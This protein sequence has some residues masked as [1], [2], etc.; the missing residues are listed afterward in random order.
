MSSELAKIDQALDE[1]RAAYAAAAGNASVQAEVKSRF[2]KVFQQRDRYLIA[3]L[4]RRAAV[5]NALTSQLEEAVMLI[6]THIANFPIGGLLSVLKDLGGGTAEGQHSGAGQPVGSA[7]NGQA[8]S[9]AGSQ[10]GAGGN[11]GTGAPSVS[12]GSTGGLISVSVSPT[13]FDALCRVAQSEVGGF[14]KYGNSELKGGLAAVVDTIINRV[15][16]KQYPNS[17]QGVVDQP[18]QFSAI[19]ST[20]SWTG[21]P[22]ANATVTEIVAEHLKYRVNGGACTVKGATHFLNP[23][24]SSST[25]LAQW[26][27]HVKEN[28]V[29]V[30]GNDAE[31]FV[32]YHGFAPGTPRTRDYLLSYEGSSSGFTAAGASIGQAQAVGSLAEKIATICNEELAYFGDGSK[33][34]GD[35]PQYL[36]VGEYW[37]S[38]GLPYDGRTQIVN[39]ATGKSHN[40]PWSS[41]F[42]SHVLKKAGAGDGFKY[43]QAHCHYVQDF[44]NGRPNGVYEAMHPDHYAPKIGDILH[45]GRGDAKQHDYNAA[46]GDYLGDSFYSSH[47]DIVVDVDLASGKITTVGG[48]V[49]NSVKTKTINIGTDG[50]L[51]PRRENGSD[52]PWIAVLKLVK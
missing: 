11:S 12:A 30:W 16:H 46:R 7:S 20:G 27:N 1:L 34:E 49:S 21:L 48:N 39:H 13:D 15:A 4:N 28:P 8:I 18:W 2:D 44:I 52:Y 25:A 23:Y 35:N 50:K 31:K 17:I 45:Y 33:K 22:V 37:A 19:N 51:K 6:Q 24:T 40:P 5:L 10:S 29:A 3:E 43:S 47:S 36:R 42:I 26:G 41:A 32:H 9:S 14:I 38:I